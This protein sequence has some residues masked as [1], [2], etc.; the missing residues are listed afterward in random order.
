[1]KNVNVGRN[2]EDASSTFGKDINSLGK[3]VP[4]RGDGGGGGAGHGGGGRML[5][6][7]AHLGAECPRGIWTI[8]NSNGPADSVV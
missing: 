7:A 1:M 6:L 8:P 3:W 2:V 5:C 4:D